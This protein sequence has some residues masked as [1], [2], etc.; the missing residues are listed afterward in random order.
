MKILRERIC[1]FAF[2]KLSRGFFLS[3]TGD[4]VTYGINLT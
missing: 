2:S 3:I 4:D 1:A